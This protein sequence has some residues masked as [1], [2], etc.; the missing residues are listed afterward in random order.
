MEEI[1]QKELGPS[2][3]EREEWAEGNEW[4]EDEN[5]VDAEVVKLDVGE[6]IE[7][8]YLDKVHSH[9]YDADCYKIKPKDSDIAKVIVG[10]TILDKKMANKEIRELVKVERIA[11]GKNQKG[12]LYQNWKTYHNKKE[13]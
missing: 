13:K 3:S 2:L 12:Q 8:I 1:K 10:T 4:E 6:S 11:D 9:K 5:N 7:G